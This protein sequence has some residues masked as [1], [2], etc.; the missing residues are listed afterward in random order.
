MLFWFL[1]GVC[2]DRPGIFQPGHIPMRNFRRDGLGSRLMKKTNGDMA[3]SALLLSFLFH[4][5][6]D[7]FSLPVRMQMQ[8]KPFTVPPPMR[9]PDAKELTHRTRFV[10]LDQLFP[11]VG[12]CASHSHAIH[13][14]WRIRRLI[15]TPCSDFLLLQQ[16]VQQILTWL[17]LLSAGCRTT[18]RR[19]GSKFRVAK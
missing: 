18:V 12:A 19:M 14:L 17:V 4:G 6:V 9:A 15:R 2:A 7:A 5:G 8:A 16:V 1:L 13:P 3:A 10:S 11:E